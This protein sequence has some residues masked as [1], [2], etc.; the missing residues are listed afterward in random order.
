[1]NDLILLFLELLCYSRAPLVD[2]HDPVYLGQ[3]SGPVGWF[4]RF[5]TTDKQPS[6][7]NPAIKEPAANVL[8]H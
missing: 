8:S 5:I 4:G 6:G 1:M 7:V 3:T 2:A